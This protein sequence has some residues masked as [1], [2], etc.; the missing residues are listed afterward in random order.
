MVV[1]RS[2]RRGP[3]E[4]RRPM[5]E[6]DANIFKTIARPLRLT[7]LGMWAER[8][9]RAFWPLWTVLIATLSAL[10]FGLQDVLPIDIAWPA[11]ILAGLAAL[12]LLWRGLRQFRRPTRTEALI[13]LDQRLPGRP[14]AALTDTQAVGL[15]DPASLAVWQ[16]H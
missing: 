11:L 16:A 9:V 15:N 8:L 1:S 3:P 10:A 2:P 5:T 7:L 13:R 4:R 12:G 14:L 6:D